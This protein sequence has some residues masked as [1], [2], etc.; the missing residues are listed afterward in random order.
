MIGT[1]GVYFGSM[2][3]FTRDYRITGE[4]H[5]LWNEY[6]GGMKPCVLDIEATGLDRTRCKVIL[7]GLLMPSFWLRITMRNQK[8][9]MLQWRC[10][11]EKA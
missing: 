2:K 8:Y 3:V 7:I 4:Y 10:S 9:W 1:F 11:R 5:P 6:F